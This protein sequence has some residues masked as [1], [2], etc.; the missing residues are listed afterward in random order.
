MSRASS[1]IEWRTHSFLIA[2]SSSGSK[3]R[4]SRDRIDAGSGM[5]ALWRAVQPPGR[6][7]RSPSR[8]H[9]L[10][11]V[12]RAPNEDVMAFSLRLRSALGPAP[13]GVRDA[14]RTLQPRPTGSA[15][16]AARH[17]DPAPVR[18]RKHVRGGAH[19]RVAL[20]VGRLV[21]VVCATRATH[22][23]DRATIRGEPI[24]D[25]FEVLLADG[26][27]ARAHVHRHRPVLARP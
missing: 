19:G 23:A 27:E 5:A 16:L 3:R 17:R 7:S 21:A 26:H 18:E 12:A 11:R 20:A 22:E 15:L 6:T 24:E 1:A 10:M 14:R 8:P 2:R 9:A 13:A 4:A 25:P